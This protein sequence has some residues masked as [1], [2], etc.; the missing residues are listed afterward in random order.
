MEMKI[1]SICSMCWCLYPDLTEI[2]GNIPMN[3]TKANTPTRGSFSKSYKNTTEM[4]Q[5]GLIHLSWY[6]PPYL[7]VEIDREDQNCSF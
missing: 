1:F 4:I 2:H 3:F 7:V 5:S 6:T